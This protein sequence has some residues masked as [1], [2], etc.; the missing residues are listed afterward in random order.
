MEGVE[1]NVGFLCTRDGCTVT[2][3]L[4]N[5]LETES[6]L[7]TSATWPH[8]HRCE[9]LGTRLL[10]TVVEELMEEETTV[11]ELMMEGVQPGCLLLYSTY[12]WHMH[13]HTQSTW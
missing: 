9:S 10:P 12:V 13:A 6:A 2:F 8:T 3:S 4:G 1:D 5:P 7:K 11:E